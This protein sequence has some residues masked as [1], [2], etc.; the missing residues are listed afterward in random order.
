L[1]NA[2]F[3]D[4]LFLRIFPPLWYALARILDRGIEQWGFRLAFL[5]GLRD[6]F[7]VSGNVLE[8]SENGLLS[9]YASG[10]I[11]GMLVLL[12]IAWGWL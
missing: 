1:F 12:I 3:F 10:M 6:G 9:R 7:A 11:L 5:G 8:S 4:H 2:W